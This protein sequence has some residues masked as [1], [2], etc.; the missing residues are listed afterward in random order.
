MV[1]RV[2]AADALV[3]RLATDDPHA[4]GVAIAAIEHAPTTPD[5]AD[6]L[7]AAGRACEDRLLDPPRALAIYQRIVRDLPDSSAAIAA[8]RRIAALRELIGA[9]GTPEAIAYARLIADAYQL[10]PDDVI[11]RADVLAT[12]AWPGA[13]VVALWLAEWLR[14]AGRFD[15]AQTRYAHVIAT[16]PT[17]PQAA[18]ASRGA[19]ACA[20]DARQWDRASTLVDRLPAIDPIDRAVHDELAA[21]VARGRRRAHLYTGAWI[22]VIVAFAALAVSLVEAALRGGARW[23]SPRPPLEILFL[24]PIALVLVVVAFTAHEAIAPAVMLIS[25]TGVALAWLSG[26]T[27]DLLRAR[28]RHVRVRAVIHVLL[29]AI[30]VASIAYIAVTRDGLLDL[31]AETVQFGPG[32]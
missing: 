19:A 27:L 8:G 4:L 5:L 16:W 15:D 1:A 25:I 22:A 9:V 32:S 17:S 31:L 30:G 29:C 13:P 18:L 12:A 21:T 7:F 26:A 14:R 10:A 24:A 6:E 2:A 28:S 3:D 11:R 23:P 20:I